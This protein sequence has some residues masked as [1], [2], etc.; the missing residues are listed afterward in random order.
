[1][2]P[3]RPA[4]MYLPRAYLSDMAEIFRPDDMN[5]YRDDE[6]AIPATEPGALPVELRECLA[7]ACIICIDELSSA[8]RQRWDKIADAHGERRTGQ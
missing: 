8:E 3:G 4:G 6:L 2:G 5:G 7:E 1:M